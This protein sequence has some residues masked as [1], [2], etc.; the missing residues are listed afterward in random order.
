M[1]SERENK[2]SI[3]EYAPEDTKID[4]VKA[5]SHDLGSVDRD[6]FFPKLV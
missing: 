3:D 5:V 6:S 1:R 2:F 4:I